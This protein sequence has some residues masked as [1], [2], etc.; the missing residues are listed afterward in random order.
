VVASYRHL[1]Q[2]FICTE[3]KSRRGAGRFAGHSRLLVC[4]S[5]LRAL[6]PAVPPASPH[7]QTDNI[8]LTSKDAGGPRRSLCRRRQRHTNASVLERP[9]Q[10]YGHR[11]KLAEGTSPRRLTYH[12]THKARYIY[13]APLHI[14]RIVLLLLQQCRGAGLGEL[15]RARYRSKYYRTC[16]HPAC[17]ARRPRL[18]R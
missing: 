13:S 15:Q 10:S 6:P 1:A 5:V 17:F 8:D 18:E 16:L 14:Y 4:A 12:C 3:I 2:P 9:P 7:T 11:L